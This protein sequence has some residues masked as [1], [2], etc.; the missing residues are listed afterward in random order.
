MKVFLVANLLDSFSYQSVRN[1]D[2]LLKFF[3]ND[4]I[5]GNNYKYFVELSIPA[6]SKYM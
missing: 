3:K 6:D 5:S 1:A 4:K 2:Y